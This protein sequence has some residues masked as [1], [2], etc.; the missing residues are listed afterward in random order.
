MRFVMAKGLQICSRH[1]ASE[2][3]EA[4]WTCCR[5]LDRTC[6]QLDYILANF[7]LQTVEVWN[8]FALPVGL[9]HRCAHCILQFQCSSPPR[10][11]R[12]RSL[13]R[14]QPTLDSDGLPARDHNI[15]HRNTI[16]GHHTSLEGLERSL[17]DAGHQGG[18]CENIHLRFR[19]WGVF[20]NLRAQ[21]RETKDAQLRKS[22]T[23]TIRKNHRQK[24]RIWKIE[25]LNAQLG[26]AR[27][28]RTLRSMQFATKGF[29][30]QQ[31]PQ[32]N[33]FADMLGQ[34][35]AGKPDRPCRP[36][37]LTENP[38]SMHELQCALG[39]LKIHKGTD[40]AGLLAELLKNSPDDF[41][42]NLLRLFDDI[43]YTGNL[44]ACWTRT[45]FQ[46]LPN[47]ARAQQPSDFRPISKIRLLYKI[48]A[49]M[50]W[51]AWRDCWRHISRKNN[52][53]SENIGGWMMMD[54]H[55]LTATL[56]LDK[57]W[58]KGI[59][60]WIVS[61]NLSKAF[62]RANW[63]ALWLALRDHGVSDQ[64]IWILQW[65]YSNQLGE[66]Q[67]EHS[68]NNPF[69]IHAGV[70]QG[71]V[72]SPRLFCSVLQWGMSVWRQ[73]AEAR[74]CSFD[75]GDNMAFL[76]DLRF[77]D[78]ILLFARTAAEA[79]ALLDDLV[80]RL[81]LNTG[82]TFVLTSEVQPPSFLATHNGC[83]LRALQQQEAHKWLG[84][85]IGAAGSRN[86][87]LDLQHH[88]QAASRAFH[89]DEWILCDKGVS[90]VHRLRYFEKAISPVACFSASHRAIHKDDLAKLDVEYRRLM[91]RVV[92]PPADTN[93][94][95]PWH[96]ILHG[97]NK[98]VQVLSDYAGLKPWSVTCVEAVW[99]FAS[100]VATLPSERWTRRILEWNIKGPR[101]RGKRKRGRPAYTWETALQRY[102]I[103]KGRG[104][105]IVEAAAYDHSMRSLQDFVFLTLYTS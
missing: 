50:I 63:N 57:A 80:H 66:V 87:Q 40:E 56:F 27:N 65:I 85:M 95:S 91:R 101:K 72:L 24:V 59:P 33:A 67:G 52:T 58:D 75:L 10:V 30:Q 7:R 9:D 15:L 21:R 47:T 4:S 74:K 49:F 105:W 73:N 88:F 60:V 79:M 84:C 31:T 89:A 37:N 38:W 103:W 18:N 61:L 46:M 26:H 23:F 36:A 13:K 68:N 22:L 96:E 45:L 100:Y 34:I 71:C 55:L 102:S 98:K 1:N 82:K 32:P 53:V 77:A 93:W 99:K 14:W 90:V 76:L 64:L 11:R 62:D 70:R 3:M 28:W 6:V 41:Q 86:T 19:P 97:W 12:Q 104:N 94:A 5:T 2:N 51:V 25:R 69:P 17:K 39:R 92:G 43:P 54:E 35:C 16:R 48:F 78:D 42:A 29:R 20:Q 83:K 44:P 8:D 81:Q